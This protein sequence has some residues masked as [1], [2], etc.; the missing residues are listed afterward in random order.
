MKN[1]FKKE[2]QKKVYQSFSQLKRQ[3]LKSG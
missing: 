1:I 2:V 3:A